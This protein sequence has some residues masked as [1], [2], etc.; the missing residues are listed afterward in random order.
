M[1]HMS[2]FLRIL[3]I[4]VLTFAVCGCASD[5]GTVEISGPIDFIA[6]LDLI[7]VPTGDIRTNA[8]ND[9]SRPIKL[10][11]E[12]RESLKIPPQNKIIFNI[13]GVPPGAKFE[14]Y[15]GFRAFE[16][17]V[18]AGSFIFYEDMAVGDDP[19]LASAFIDASAEGQWDE[20]SIDLAEFEGKALKIRLD[21]STQTS[22]LSSFIAQPR[23]VVNS[24]A[25]PKRAII[26]CIDTLRTDAL[27]VYGNTE[28]MTPSLDAFAADAVRFANCESASPWTLPSCASFHT[29][30]FPGMIAADAITEHLRGEETTLAE[31][32]RAA[33]YRCGS[34]T[35]NH[36]VSSEV[37]FF[38]GNEYQREMTVASAD[39][40]L[41]D[42]LEFIQKH[43]E[44][45]SLT[46]IHLFDSHVP[47]Q[48]RE[49]YMSR[50][51]AGSGRFE[52]EFSQPNE[53]R[54]G[55]I[56][57]TEEEKLQIHGL[58]KGC[59]AFEDSELGK[60]FDKLK[61]L[62]L[63]DDS[64]IVI[65]ADHGEELWDHGAFEHGHSVY[66]EVTN[67]P[68]LIKF[69]GV[70]S[71]VVE[72]RVSLV[73]VMPTLLNW[74][75]LDMP[76][77]IVGK[78]LLVDDP[79]VDSTRKMFIE[80]CIHSTEKRASI[81][82]DWK[83]ILNMAVQAPPELY[84]LADD[85]HEQV[86]M[87]ETETDVT[88]LLADELLLYSA[89]TDEGGHIRLYNLPDITN[90]E[91]ELTAEVIDGEFSDVRH[92]YQ[93]VLV[94][95]SLGTLKL[96]SKVKLPT[97][98]YIGFDFNVEPETA[99]VKFTARVIGQPEKLFPWYLGSSAEPIQ[100][101]VFQLNI[102]DERVSMSYPQAR[103]TTAEGIY[104]WSV[105]RM[106]RD[107]LEN[108]ISPETREELNSL[109]YIQ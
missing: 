101:S 94:N 76:D 53:V 79:K 45:D 90:V 95:E 81:S 51:R 87:A 80:Q 22:S 36:Y 62:G 3:T 37:G 78:D 12:V 86:N 99:I 103:L 17:S 91:Y 56:V 20:V 75:D 15:V 42:G 35:N 43:A 107:A 49:P 55:E 32:F 92:L 4:T 19:K 93:G 98:G 63:Y 1:T 24:G 96:V 89:H 13:P 52:T 41:H 68:L 50:Y 71:K 100:S 109:G 38:Q 39:I 28:G 74:F 26:I 69:P 6:R 70:D 57:L 5:G 60:F 102:V 9:V 33:G 7:Q 25:K 34:I 97:N 14:C 67:V 108:T 18:P 21:S 59:V 66:E 40:E 27:G 82:G 106:V 16:G 83:L 61:E 30:R 48:P 44:E 46:Y 104:I 47:Y 85:P 8:Y 73:D 88:K 10:G 54:S 58:Y 23:L 65:F 84:N 72:K 31:V 105:P 64:V 2:L 29:G 11:N 77:G